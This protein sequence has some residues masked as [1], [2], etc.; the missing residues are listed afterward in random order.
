MRL[1]GD[2][3]SGNCYKVWLLA[4]YLAIPLEWVHVD[5]AAGETRT[6][7][8]LAMNPNGKIPVLQL[9]DGTLLCESNAILYLLAQGSPLWPSDPLAQARVLQWL[10]FEQYSHE[11]YVAVSRFIVL[12]L[13]RPADQ[14]A[15]LLSLREPARKALAVMECRLAGHE[16]LSG[17]T[18]TIAD[19]ALYAYTHVAEE[20]ELSLDP[21]PAVR[22]WLARMGQQPLH[23]TLNQALAGEHPTGQ[24]RSAPHF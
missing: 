2:L 10:F 23:R 3:R 16:W 22:G 9:E 13:G 20:G 1:Y 21:F 8:F 18:M 11:P 5:I 4:R 6:P 7:A 19:I 14:E 15:R 24:A 17:D 12:Y